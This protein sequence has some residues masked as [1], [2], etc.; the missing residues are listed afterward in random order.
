MH[1]VVCPIRKCPNFSPDSVGENPCCIQH[2]SLYGVSQLSCSV[3]PQFAFQDYGS[4]R[5]RVEKLK[6]AE[7]GKAKSE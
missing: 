5:G 4:L 3:Y 7:M 6:K 1:Q 2:P